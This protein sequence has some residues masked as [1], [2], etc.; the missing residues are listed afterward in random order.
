MEH[1]DPK[2]PDRLLRLKAYEKAGFKKLDPAHVNYHQPDFRAPEEIDA[3][4]G[5]RPLPFGLIVRQV[6]RE[7]DQV[8]PGASVREIQECLYRMYGAGFREKD[9]A[10]L[11][12]RVGEYPRAEAEVPLVAPTQSS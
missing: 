5:P 11:W 1:P 7:H 2:F 12:Q 10:G 3:S 9:M 4:G 8:I 6:G